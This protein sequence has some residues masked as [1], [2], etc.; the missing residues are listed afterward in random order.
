MLPCWWNI[1]Q[2]TCDSIIC[3]YAF[4]TPL[5]DINLYFVQSAD[6]TSKT[7]KVLW[8]YFRKWDKPDFSTSKISHGL[9]PASRSTHLIYQAIFDHQVSSALFPSRRLSLS[10]Q[11]YHFLKDKYTNYSAPAFHHLGKKRENCGIY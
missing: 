11:T 4:K 6:C 8:N 1:L 5:K 7:D 9:F 10:L 3:T 2:C